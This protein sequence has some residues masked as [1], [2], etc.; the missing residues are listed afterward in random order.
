MG[1]VEKGK[2]AMSKM[3]IEIHPNGDPFGRGFTGSQSD[4]G[5]LSWYYRGDIGAMPRRWWRA[6]CRLNYYTLR[7]R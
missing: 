5:G 1:A 6:Y 2:Y 7:E 4:D 3:I